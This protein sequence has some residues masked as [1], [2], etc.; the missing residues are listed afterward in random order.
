[1]EPDKRKILREFMLD[2]VRGH[3]N[4]PVE[5]LLSKKSSTG[6]ANVY[7]SGEKFTSQVT[8]LGKLS[9]LGTYQT[10]EEAARIS[11]IARQKVSALDFWPNAEQHI[12]NVYVSKTDKLIAARIFN[13]RD[14]GEDGSGLTVWSSTALYVEAMAKKRKREELEA[15]RAEAAPKRVERQRAAAE[16]AERQRAA[17]A[18]RVERR[19]LF[20]P[21]VRQRAEDTWNMHQDVLSQ[22]LY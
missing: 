21:L 7:S 20:E 1:M 15:E 5:L 6:F 10:K 13:L 3:G 12:N 4:G 2:A 9:D 14:L 11:A 8:I 19:A 22:P 18:E 16:R 17:A